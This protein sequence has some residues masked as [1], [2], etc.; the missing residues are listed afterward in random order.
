MKLKITPLILIASLG[1]MSIFGL[2]LFGYMGH[3]DQ[4]HEGCPLFSLASDTC[5]ALNNQLSMIV[6]HLSL[7]AVFSKAFIDI[8][9]MK[10]IFSAILFLILT[11]FGK[12]L[13]FSPSLFSI[14]KTK[15]LIFDFHKRFLQWISLKN[16]LDPWLSPWARET[17]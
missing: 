8:E 1:L 2:W 7:L 4:Q 5:P 3:G 13:L 15:E 6:Y 11:V 10:I 16:K 17:V 12:Q 14:R 9:L